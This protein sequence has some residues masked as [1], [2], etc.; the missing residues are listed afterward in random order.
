[1]SFQNRLSHISPWAKIVLLLGLM[2]SGTLAVL[3]ILSTL[4]VLFFDFPLDV[5]KHLSPTSSLRSIQAAKIIQITTQIG[6]FVL[7]TFAFA[8]LTSSKLSLGIGWE[9]HTKMTGFFVAI[10]ATILAIPF[11]NI[12]AEW[13]TALHLPDFMEPL[14]RWMRQTQSSNDEMLKILAPMRNPYDIGINVLMMAILPAIGEELL[15]RGVLQRQFQTIFRNPHVAILVTAIIFS[16]IHLQFL[17]FFS[18]TLLGMLFGYLFYF[19]KNIWLPIIA[20]FI[21]NF[22]ALMLVLF[23]GVNSVETSME[24]WVTGPF[25]LFSITSFSAAVF[26]VYSY[27][28]SFQSTKV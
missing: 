16:A 24:N 6:L 4:N 25:I 13:N 17:G 26:I 21:N 11:I 14:E 27:R 23:Y 20:H 8:Y 3:S 15:F 22:L 19:S 9:Y 2:A 5:V 10:G 12:L 18:R 7:P 1:M 28:N